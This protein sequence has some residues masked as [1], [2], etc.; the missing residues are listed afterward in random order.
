MS[1]QDQGPTIPKARGALKNCAVDSDPLS[2]RDDALRRI[3]ADKRKALV[4]L[5]IFET[6]ERRAVQR[7]N[8][9]AVLAA[10]TVG[11]EAVRAHLSDLSD[12]RDRWTA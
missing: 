4:S 5:R 3:D 9:C 7:G 1:A 10:V 2:P 12:Q 8:P 11:L 6:A